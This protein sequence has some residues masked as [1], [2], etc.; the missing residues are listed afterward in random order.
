MH[1]IVLLGAFLS[2]CSTVP[3]TGPSGAVAPG[4]TCQDGNAAQFIG[5]LASHE[6]GTAVLRATKSAALRW[7]PPGVMLTMD[8]RADRVTVRTGPDGRIT[9]INCG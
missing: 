9:G 4:G 1:R 2:A 7:A 8:F 6:S 5:Q 3:A